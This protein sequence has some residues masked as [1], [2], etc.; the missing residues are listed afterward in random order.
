MQITK[1]NRKSVIARLNR[2]GHNIPPTT[3]TKELRAYLDGATPRPGGRQTLAQALAPGAADAGAVDDLETL[4]DAAHSTVAG[5]HPDFV[6]FTPDIAIQ[7]DG[8]VALIVDNSNV[9]EDEDYSEVVFYIGP[10]GRVLKTEKA[11]GPETSKAH[12][13]LLT[14][15]GRRLLAANV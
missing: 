13:Q 14:D 3:T 6:Y 5:Q 9:E 10:S 8:S 11:P 2:E 4:V 7:N 1:A 12:M 15:Y